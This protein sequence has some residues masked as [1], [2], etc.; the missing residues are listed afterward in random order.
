MREQTTQYCNQESTAQMRPAQGPEALGSAA[1]LLSL[2]RRHGNLFVQRLLAQ[3][4]RAEKHVEAGPE[5]EDAI[6]QM[7]GSGYSIEPN[8]RAQAAQAFGRDFSEVRI[9]TDGRAQAMS[10]ALG[11]RAFT[12]GKDIF[13][14]R[15]EYHPGSTA[16]RELLAHELTHVVQQSGASIHRKLTVS[17]PGDEHEREADQVAA[18][19][20]QWWESSAASGAAQLSTDSNLASQL[21]SQHSRRAP[22][23]QNSTERVT[24]Q[25]AV[26]QRAPVKIQGF[27]SEIVGG[28]IGGALGTAVGGGGWRS[29]GC[30]D[31]RHRGGCRWSH[32]RPFYGTEAQRAGN[33]S[34]LQERRCRVAPTGNSWA[35][36]IAP[37]RTIWSK[38]GVSFNV[39]A[40]VTLEDAANKSA[41]GS[42]GERNAIRAT[43]PNGGVKVF[44]VDNDV[45]DAGGGGTVNTSTSESK[46]VLSDRGASDTLLAH[47][48]GHSLG[49]GHPPD[50][51]DTDTVMEPTGSNA[52]DNPTRNTMDNYNRITWPAGGLTLLN[53]DS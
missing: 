14:N 17:Q 43:Q 36:R 7:R 2:Q 39:A 31:R 46:I 1:S 33:T 3:A 25:F 38:L 37:A 5:L 51:A 48:L 34:F 13:F 40:A 30:S 23:V 18:Q 52:A 47:E 28:V 12:T 44:M 41:G 50:E 35:R 26:Q 32:A 42:L 16:G 29:C 24:P 6:H 9:H 19:V 21:E 20:A 53:P 49:L 22:Q 27:W 8:V 45:A 10:E 11:A 4:M 15:G